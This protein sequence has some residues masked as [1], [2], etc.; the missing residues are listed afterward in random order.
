[1]KL[2]EGKKKNMSYAMQ[3]MTLQST[4]P[5]P[6]FPHARQALIDSAAKKKASADDGASSS[7]SD[8]D[9]NSKPATKKSKIEKLF[10][11][12]NQVCEPSRFKLKSSF[13]FYFESQGLFVT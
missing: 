12:Q 11:R 8:A 10:T 5:C 7:S 2:G 4:L 9:A 3:V 13:F 6:L 1:M